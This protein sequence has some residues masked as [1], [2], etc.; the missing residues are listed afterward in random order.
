MTWPSSPRPP[1]PG[2]SREIW[3]N[4]RG[5]PSGAQH[6]GR[7]FLFSPELPLSLG[8]RGREGWEDKLKSTPGQ[9][10]SWPRAQS[11]NLSEGPPPSQPSHNAPGAPAD[12]AGQLGRGPYDGNR[13]E[14]CLS[15]RAVRGNSCSVKCRQIRQKQLRPGAYF[16]PLFFSVVLF[17]FPSY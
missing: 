6:L 2:A 13:G 3:D 14:A 12:K 5:C 16:P 10:G 17:Q 9:Q 7:S 4:L 11:G 15:L 1:S 8:R